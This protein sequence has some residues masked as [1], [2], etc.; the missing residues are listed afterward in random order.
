VK[1]ILSKANGVFLW[2]HLVTRSLLNGIKYG[3]DVATLQNR[4]KATPPKLEDLYAHML[5][6]IEPVL[7]EHASRLFQIYNAASDVDVRPTV[8]ELDLAVTATYVEAMTPIRSVVSEEEIEERCDK[9]IS[10]L[11]VRCGGLLE[12]HDRMDTGWEANDDGEDEV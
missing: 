11:K 2:V 4:L 7:M 3:D 9:M 10:Y 1:E 8:L 5:S 6:S 12:A